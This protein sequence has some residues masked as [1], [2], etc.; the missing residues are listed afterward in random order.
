MVRRRVIEEPAKQGLDRANRAR[1]EPVEHLHRTPGIRAGRSAMQCFCRQPKIRVYR[2]SCRFLRDD[3]E[4]QAEAGEDPAGLKKAETGELT[5]P[6][7]DEVRFP[8]APTL[9]I[10]D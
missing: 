4:K 9:G 7:Q 3:P 6:G 8:M 1:A 10:K 5:L 2:P